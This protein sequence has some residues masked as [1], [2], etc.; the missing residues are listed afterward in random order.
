MHQYHQRDIRHSPPSGPP[1][2]PRE[3]EQARQ[4]TMKVSSILLTCSY[5]GNPARRAVDFGMLNLGE[6]QWISPPPRPHLGHHQQQPLPRVLTTIFSREKNLCWS[7]QHPLDLSPISDHQPQRSHDLVFNVCI[8]PPTPQN[9]CLENVSVDSASCLPPPQNVV[10]PPPKD[11]S[12]PSSALFNLSPPPM[13]QH[14]SVLFSLFV[15]SAG[16]ELPSAG[17]GRGG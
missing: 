11:T 1:L 4:I 15:P 16:S 13:L 7:S 3:D 2:G 5:E 8:V 17:S 10:T 14:S 12:S 6:H 9:H